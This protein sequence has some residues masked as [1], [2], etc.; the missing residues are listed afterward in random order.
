[1]GRRVHGET[2]KA[3]ERMGGGVGVSVRVR[4]RAR[5]REGGSGGGSCYLRRR[6]H[7]LGR[8]PARL[9]LDLDPADAEAVCGRGRCRRLLLAGLRLGPLHGHR[10][11]RRCGHRPLNP[12]RC[13]GLGLLHPCRRLDHRC[14]RHH[15]R[16]PRRRRRAQPRRVHLRRPR[17]R[18]RRLLLHHG[19]RREPRTPVPGK[20]ARVERGRGVS[21]G[22]GRLARRA[23]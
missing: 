1:M 15:R 6:C 4:A 11:R 16:S 18:L 10:R 20:R 2:G 8:P 9:A 21:D 19:G 13:G 5:V 17:R 23:V 12:C 22:A 7:D 14:R 3:A